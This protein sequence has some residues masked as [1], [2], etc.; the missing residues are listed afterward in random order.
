MALIDRGDSEKEYQDRTEFI[1]MKSI[2]FMSREKPHPIDWDKLD[3][4][5]ECDWNDE[6]E[7]TILR[8]SLFFHSEQKITLGKLR[9]FFTPK[10]IKLLEKDG[11]V[12][13]NLNFD[14]MRK[15]AGI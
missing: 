15:E 8:A 12:K 5:P 1:P 6:V 9:E 4:N 2:G 11:Y 7:V 14:E 13:L 3:I 10:A